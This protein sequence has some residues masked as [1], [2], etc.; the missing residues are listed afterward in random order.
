MNDERNENELRMAKMYSTR[1]QIVDMRIG[2][3]FCK[4]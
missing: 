3:K 1:H 2:R 4:Q